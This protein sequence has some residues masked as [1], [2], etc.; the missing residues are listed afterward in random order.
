MVSFPD[1]PAA[2]GAEW[3]QSE[4]VISL[5]GKWKFNWVKTPAERPYW[6][7]RDD[8]D[9]RS[10]SEI[11]VPSTWEREGYGTPY[12]V[13]EGYPFKVN[14]PFIEHSNNPVGSYKRTFTVPAGWNNKEVFLTFDGVA[15]AFYVWVNGE[16]AGYSEESKTTSEFNIT[17]YLKGGR[18]SVSVEVYRWCDGSYLEGQDFFRLSGIQRS[19]WLHARPRSYIRDYFAESTLTND[20]KDGSLALSVELR[21]RGKK[22]ENLRLEASLY[23]GSTK[24]FGEI[25]EAGEVADTAVVKLNAEIPGVKAWSAE[26]PSLYTIVLTL[27][28]GRGNILESVTSHI[29]FRT[30]EVKGTQFL[31]NGKAVHLKGTN[32]HEHHYIKGHTIDE[33]T[34]LKDIRL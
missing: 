9:T 23:E 18:N 34:M 16:M 30:S 3:R 24:I 32:M 2:L 13:D 20:Y 8:Y 17:P 7:F 21:N 1:N 22:A 4:N 5:D 11:E 19:V 31:I 14:P 15:S 25:K 27:A 33:A 29:G 10:W 28:D 6:F 26:S 12:Y